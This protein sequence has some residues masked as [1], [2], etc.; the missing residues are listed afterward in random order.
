M[1]TVLITPEAMLHDAVPCVDVLKRAGFDVIFPEDPT[2]TRGLYSEQ[3]TIEVLSAGTAVIAGG[4]YITRNVVRELPNLR[5]IARAGV[6]F[7]RVDVTAATE[8]NVVVTITPT[9]NHECVAEQA[10][11]LVFAVARSLVVNDRATRNGAWRVT[12]TEPLRG[13]TFGILGL[14]RVGRSLA[15]RTAALG[16]QVI[17]YELSPDEMFLRAHNVELVDFDE[18]LARSDYVSLHCP[19]NDSTTDLF[20]RKVFAKMKPGSVL[21]NTARGKLVVEADLLDALNSGH[22]RGAG[23]DVF[24]QEPAAADNPLFALDQVVVS[25]HV[26]GA[27]WLAMDNMGIEA[28]RCIVQLYN[29]QWPDGAVVNQE[30]K[31]SWRW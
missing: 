28:A 11:A 26:G 13:R 17:A 7:D 30:L 29:G 20:D 8:R 21:I 1:P 19:L 5:V 23:L 4:E 3:E 15:T 22:L 2:F 31:H 12:L 6:G 14:G 25:P 10:L 24:E 9:A 27:D 16:M 18:L